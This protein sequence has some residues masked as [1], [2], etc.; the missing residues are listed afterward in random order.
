MRYNK[1]SSR[2]TGLLAVMN[3]KSHDI[4][5]DEDGITNTVQTDKATLMPIKAHIKIGIAPSLD[6]PAKPTVSHTKD[7]K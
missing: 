1:L 3:V 4:T 5:I 2:M 6:P 7:T